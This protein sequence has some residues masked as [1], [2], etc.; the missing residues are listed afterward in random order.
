MSDA[1]VG[2]SL[3]HCVIHVGDWEVARH[4]YTAVMGAQAI[5]VDVGY[6]FRWGNQQLNCHGPNK[7]AT[8]VAAKPVQPG[9]SD[10]CFV[11]PGPI[12]GAIAH[13]AAH[14]VAIELGPVPR[15]GAQGPGTSI[16][17][18]DPDGSLMEFMSYE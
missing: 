8:P 18:R 5:A 10:L 15:F 7:A 14:D 2:I 4:F 16:Y 12:D 17:F 9:N 3:D 1:P 13:L 11:W 6:V